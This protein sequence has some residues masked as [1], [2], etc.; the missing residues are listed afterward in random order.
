MTNWKNL[1]TRSLVLLANLVHNNTILIVILRARKVI[2]ARKKRE[3][4]IKPSES[5]LLLFSPC[6][7]LMMV[8]FLVV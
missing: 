4:L 2:T 5:K 3:R 7:S 8:F 6:M 1:V